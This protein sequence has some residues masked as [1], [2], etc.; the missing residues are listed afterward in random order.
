[1]T[2]AV[3]GQGIGSRCVEVEGREA[4][5]TAVPALVQAEDL[6]VAVDPATARAT[7]R[8]SLPGTAHAAVAGDTLVLAAGDTAVGLEPGTG[9]ERWRRELPGSVLD[10]GVSLGQVVAL[11]QQ[12]AV[13]ARTSLLALDPISGAIAY[14]R[15][16][17]GEAAGLL[18]A[19]DEGLVIVRNRPG[20]TPAVT[21][22]LYARSRAS[23]SS[24][25]PAASTRSPRARRGSWTDGCS[26]ASCAT[27]TRCGSRPRTS[28]RAR[29]AG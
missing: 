27:A 23:A 26:S 22:T 6:V 19:A 9:V 8:I 17:D 4:A 16:L 25:C 24:S 18:R 5:E 14:R 1:M 15:D 20:A 2:E 7:W 10:L 13:S 21:A 11:L 29:C 28:P 3:D 12:I